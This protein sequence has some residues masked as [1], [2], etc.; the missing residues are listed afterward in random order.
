[1][2]MSALTHELTHESTHALCTQ[3]SEFCKSQL[4]SSELNH[5][6]G[7]YSN[8]FLNNVSRIFSFFNT[9]TYLYNHLSCPLSLLKT[10]A[11]ANPLIILL[12]PFLLLRPKLFPKQ[13][14]KPYLQHLYPPPKNVVFETTSYGS[15][16]VKTTQMNLPIKAT[17]PSSTADIVT[18]NAIALNQ[19]PL[20][21]FTCKNTT[22]SISV[23]PTKA[24]PLSFTPC[25]LTHNS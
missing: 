19:T 21:G 9:T 18:P 15:I 7:P 13:S 8:N 23:L 4:M 20:S 3:S 12:I 10:T 6:H 24:T 5:M 22:T 11:L 14:N 1:M 25:E 16:H 17:A 2:P